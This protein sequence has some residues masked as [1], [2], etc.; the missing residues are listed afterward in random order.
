MTVALGSAG[1]LDV[2]VRWKRKTL[3]ELIPFVPA[4]PVAPAAPSCAAI[5]GV[6]HSK[7]AIESV[8][9]VLLAVAVL[10]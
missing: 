10:T 4:A 3:A 5:C 9:A 8:L 2:V 7:L 6:A 1:A